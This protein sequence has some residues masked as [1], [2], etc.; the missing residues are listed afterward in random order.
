MMLTSNMQGLIREWPLSK[1]DKILV[2]YN[3]ET[4]SFCE[5]FSDLHQLIGLK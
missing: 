4:V 2:F 3:S 5:L 1:N